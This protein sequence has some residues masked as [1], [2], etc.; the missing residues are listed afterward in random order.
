MSNRFEAIATIVRFLKFLQ[1]IR[2]KDNDDLSTING[3][4]S[5]SICT[6][7]PNIAHTQPT[8]H[9]FMHKAEIVKCCKWKYRYIKD[10][11]KLIS[12]AGNNDQSH[13]LAFI[14]TIY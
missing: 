1:E 6:G 11:Q 10:E 4:M 14:F 3:L 7:L 8:V 12:N 13:L 2:V 9:E 5:F